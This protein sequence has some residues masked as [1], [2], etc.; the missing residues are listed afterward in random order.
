M[1]YTMQGLENDHPIREMLFNLLPTEIP[2]RALP[3]A[4]LYERANQDSYHII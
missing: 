3:F 1:I 4:D 2:E